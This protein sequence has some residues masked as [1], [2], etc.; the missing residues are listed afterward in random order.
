MYRS[1]PEILLFVSMGIL[2]NLLIQQNAFAGI[3]MFF[4]ELYPKELV[5]VV[6]IIALP[7]MTLLF[8]HPLILFVVFSQSFT[9]ILLGVGYAPAA[10]YLVWIIMFISSQLLSPTSLATVISAKNSGK[11]IFEESFIK[12]YAF[13]IKLTVIGIAYVFVVRVV[14]SA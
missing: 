11:T 5:V 3:L 9:E 13:C 6:I 8:I 14:N 4:E 7:L 1:L 2:G 12:H 10:V